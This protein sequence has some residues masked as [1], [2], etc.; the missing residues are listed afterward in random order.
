MYEF[1]APWGALAPALSA[2]AMYLIVKEKR[3]QSMM[4]ELHEPADT[5]AFSRRH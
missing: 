3:R 4:I 5:E 2:L 1:L